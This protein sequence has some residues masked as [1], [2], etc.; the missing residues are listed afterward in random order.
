MNEEAMAEANRKLQ[1]E[2]V[3]LL[4]AKQIGLFVVN[5]LADRQGLRVELRESTNGGVAA[6]VFIPENLVATT[7]PSTKRHP[8]SRSPTSEDLRGLT[9]R[10][11]ASSW[12]HTVTYLT[13]SR[14]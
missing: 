11:V 5:R 14:Q 10:G 12:S 4:N 2:K 9:M 13:G 6:A 8:G 7:C 3:D 1:F